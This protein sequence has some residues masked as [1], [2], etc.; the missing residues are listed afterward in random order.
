MTSLSLARLL[1]KQYPQAIEVARRAIQ[2]DPKMIDGHF[3]LGRALLES[4]DLNG[5]RAERDVLSGLDK[6]KAEELSKRIGS[7]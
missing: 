2:L 3:Y 7:R 4:G 6:S 1:L 5:A